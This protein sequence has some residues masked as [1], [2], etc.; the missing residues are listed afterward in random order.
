MLKRSL[1]LLALATVPFTLLAE[2]PPLAVHRTNGAIAIDGKLDDA[3]WK[4]AAV[5][6][7]FYETSPADNTPPKVKT[8]AWVTYDERYFYI[9]VRCDDPEPAKIRAPFVDRDA[10]IGT[11]DNVA[12]FLDTRNDKRS[13][14]EL[15]VNPRGIQGDGI[16]NDAN[17]NEDFSPDFF[18]DTAASID[19]GGWSAEYRVPFSSLRYSNGDPQ[20]W[21]I[22]VWRNYPRDFRYAFQS[23]VMPRS[24]N[25]YI[26]H[27]HPLTGL[28][29][30]PEAGHLVAAPYV[31]AQGFSHP[32]GDILGHRLE[33]DPIRT[34][35][36]LDLKYNPT[37]NVTLDLTANPDFSQVEADVAQI[38]VNQRFAVFYP[39]KRPFFLEGFDLFD[40]P[41]QVAYTRTITA[42]RWGVRSTGKL[43]ATAYTL[44]VSQDGGGG[45]VILPGPLGNDFAAQDF[46]SLAT[47]GRVRHDIGSS[48]V[49]MVLTDREL[50][51]G[52]HNRVIGPDF[53]WR[54]NGSDAV[55]GEL[56]YSQTQ[57]PNRPDLLAQWTGKSRDDI[58]ASL[59]WNHLKEKYDWFVL[60]KQLGEDFRADL[61]FLPQVGYREYQGYSGLRFYPTKGLRF[62]RPSIGFDRQTDLDGHTIFQQTSIAVDMNGPRNLQVGLNVRPRE[63]VF[64][65]TSQREQTYGSFFVQFDPSRRFT[66]IGIQGRAGQSIDF[67]N[68]RV[69]HG[70]SVLAYATLR[71]FDQLTFDVQANR[72]WLDADGGRVFTAQVER[73][74]TTYSFSAKSLVRGIVQYV[75][76]QRAPE[77][78]SFPVDRHSGNFLGSILYSYKLNWQTVL[79][80]GYGDDRI[81]T[82]QNDLVRQDRSLFFKVSYALQR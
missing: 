71:P 66:R 1:F 55:T 77:Q 70:A 39:E 42:P 64:V 73:L 9:G 53:Q 52:G 33:N 51:H 7:T 12:V 56:L 15:R 49:G 36:G 46:R 34:D 59:S 40:T 80:V 30:L 3:G 81:I 18:Y 28:T 78:Y 38:T 57:D 13:A 11:D 61:G 5:I 54:P 63:S 35:A 37:A 24:S 25:C 69:G 17:G 8:T 44:L 45:L 4:D 2:T 32:S 82:P 75:S 16:F 14:I 67:A 41:M 72:E 76:T 48:F 68:D 19:A 60:A 26:C 58:A 10:V 43:G 22:L 62:I 27:M 79:F 6:D 23:A 74:K 21:N 47:I 29:G 31:T 65:R 20:T 50:Q